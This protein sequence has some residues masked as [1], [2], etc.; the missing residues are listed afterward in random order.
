LNACVLEI[1]G[2]NAHPAA[3]FSPV[4]YKLSEVVDWRPE[5]AEKLEIET[6]VTRRRF[7]DIERQPEVSIGDLKYQPAT[8]S[9]LDEDSNYT[10]EIIFKSPTLAQFNGLKKHFK[11][12]SPIEW[13]AGRN[14]SLVEFLAPIAQA[15]IDSTY[16]ANSSLAKPGL[17]TWTAP[18]GIF[19]DQERIHRTSNCY[20]TAYEYLRGSTSSMAIHFVREGTMDG[21]FTDDA[22]S[23]AL[24]RFTPAEIQKAVESGVIDGRL[25]KI[26]SGDLLMF[27]KKTY[28]GS[29]SYFG[30]VHTAIA[31]DKDLVFEKGNPGS[32]YPFRI[33]FLKSVVTRLSDTNDYSQGRIVV[34]RFGKKEIPPASKL[35]GLAKQFELE[36]RYTQVPLSERPD[37]MFQQNHGIAPKVGSFGAG[38]DSVYEFKDIPL[39]WDQETQRYKFLGR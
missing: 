22:Y 26:A 17:L 3:L 31:I 23:R 9:N 4:E 25:T 29:H 1:D 15:A 8:T 19:F 6:Q 5:I 20:S 33:A 37:L 30:L 10:L 13:K 18:F 35:F 36:Y 39:S 28:I 16:L 34:R 14:Y 24:L 21:F 7:A 11:T 38:W 12:K 32:D 2:P 27:Q